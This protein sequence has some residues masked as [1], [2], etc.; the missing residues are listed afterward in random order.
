MNSDYELFRRI[1]SAGSLT[2]AGRE[3]HLSPAMV[4]KRLTRLEARLGVRLIHRTTRKLVTTDVRQTFY[5]DVSTILEHTKLAE[6]RVAGRIHTPCGRL[7]ITAP[8]LATFFAVKSRIEV[9]MLLDDAFVDLVSDRIDI[10][11]S[12]LRSAARNLRRTSFDAKPQDFVRCAFIHFEVWVSQPKLK[13][14]RST[15][16]WQQSISLPGAWKARMISALWRQD[17]AS[18]Q[19]R[20]ALS[21]NLWDFRGRDR[22]AIDLG[23]QR[24]NT[25]RKIGS[26]FTGM[27]VPGRRGYIRGAAAHDSPH[28]SEYES[29]HCQHMK[30]VC[31]IAASTGGER[32]FNIEI[33]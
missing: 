7:R 10:A 9:E 15:L 28:A 24:R 17:L 6:S 23:C 5:E 33:K 31:Q 3:L 14:W 16:C 2:A 25:V 13:I 8:H 29:F 27:A 20:V 30:S 4:S 32:Q 18:S 12:Y 19:T 11:I 1:V 22:I 26:D 21:V